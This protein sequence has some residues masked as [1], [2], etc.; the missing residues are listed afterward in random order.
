MNL[1]LKQVGSVHVLHVVGKIEGK[2]SA[3]LRAGV[4]KLIQTGKDRIVIDLSQS[5]P[6]P[7]DLAKEIGTMHAV[8]SELGG[9]IALVVP[10]PEGGSL[11]A[12]VGKGGLPIVASTEEA[13]RL[14]Q[15]PSSSGVESK[16]DSQSL[17]Q[18]R[19]ARIKMLEGQIALQSPEELRRLRNE[20]A[21]L[22]ELVKSLE[23]QVLNF[24]AERRIPP[25][26]E[27]VK[28]RIDSLEGS[29]AEL[30][31]ALEKGAHAKK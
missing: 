24:S 7:A 1:N 23:V 31:S 6:L 15:V 12:S 30:S 13:I 2:D 17:L 25:D 14:C 19:D 3:V 29:V 26:A 18:E 10:E 28:A 9:K 20:N 16:S 21:Q 11:R 27:A 5:T 22:K 8:T 4:S